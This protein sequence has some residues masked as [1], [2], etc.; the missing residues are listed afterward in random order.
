MSDRE[1]CLLF[2]R[3]F[4]CLEDGIGY[5]DCEFHL[6]TVSPEYEWGN[7]AA[8]TLFFISIKAS[9]ALLPFR[10]PYHALSG[11][12]TIGVRLAFSKQHSQS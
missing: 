1:F 3:L 8:V 4:A 5:G 11:S 9:V 2:W 12:R 7:K 10:R 6:S